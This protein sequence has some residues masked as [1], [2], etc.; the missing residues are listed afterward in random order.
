MD[1]L[2]GANL[3]FDFQLILRCRFWH[4]HAILF[5]FV[6]FVLLV[7]FVSRSM[8]QVRFFFLAHASCV[9][10][11]IPPVVR[12]TSALHLLHVFITKPALL[13]QSL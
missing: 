6:D 5:F 12:N 9:Y 13:M 11:S 10:Y 1:N 2:R 8:V 3:A 4:V 7:C